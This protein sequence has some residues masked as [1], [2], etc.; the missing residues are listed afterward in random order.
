[1]GQTKPILMG[2]GGTEPHAVIEWWEGDMAK[3]KTICYTEAEL[4]DSLQSIGVHYPSHRPVII[5]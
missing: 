5:F 1:M 4:A 2:F 3:F